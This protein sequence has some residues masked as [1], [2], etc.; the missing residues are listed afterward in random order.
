M[1]IMR[2]DLTDAEA[3]SKAVEGQDAIISLLGPTGNVAGTPF[4][5]AYHLI[6][7]LM[8]R[9]GV[10][11]ILAMGTSSIPDPQDEFSIIAFLGVTLIRIIANSAYK[12]IVS[13]GK[14][15]DTEATKDG[16][17]W[18]IFR[19]GFLGNGA[20]LSSKAGYIGK[21]GWVMK[22]QR[23]DVATWL[24]AEVENNDSEWIKK[25]PSLW[26]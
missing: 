17:D 2:G 11:R 23:A 18:T 3:L 14:L 12:D 22:N 25:K 24:V 16:L 15:F 7:S 8:K 13:V 9:W 1:Q 4:T 26:S 5:D 6:F 19:L 21:N 10:R 20:P